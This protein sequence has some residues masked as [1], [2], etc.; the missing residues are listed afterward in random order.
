MIRPKRSWLFAPGMDERKM[1][2]AAASAADALIFD[3]EDAVA[4]SEK[5]RARA[6]IRALLEQQ[7]PE[8]QIYVRVNDMTTGWTAEDLQAVCVAGLAGIILPKVE[9]AETI[10]TVSALIDGAE[11]AAGLSPGQVRL[12]AIIETARGVV[13]IASIAEAAS[14]LDLL[15][16][17]AGDYTADLGIPTSNLGP[18]IVHAKIA[19]VVASRAAGL[20]APVDTVFFDLTD[21]EGLVADCAQAKALGFQGKAVI[22]PNQIAC[23]NNGFTPTSS[24]IAAAQRVVDPFREAERNGIGA[25][26]LDGKLIDYAM[27]KAAGKTLA[28]AQV[29]H[30]S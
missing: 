8:R 24:E 15:M 3:L 29:L 22:H 13:H 25:V 23:V 12:N 4:I 2:K 9:A 17:G 18:H 1:G 26:Q 16:F 28:I 14:R 11:R 21:Q 5:P 30:L 19:T 10:R 6:M 20:A 27:L 7:S